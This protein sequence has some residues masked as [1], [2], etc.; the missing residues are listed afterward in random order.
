MQGWP[1]S[2]LVSLGLL[3]NIMRISSPAIKSGRNPCPSVRRPH[4]IDSS[5]SRASF[6]LGDPATQQ[7]GNRRRRRSFHL[8]FP[9]IRDTGCCWHQNNKWVYICALSACCSHCLVGLGLFPVLDACPK[10]QSLDLTSCRG[11]KVVDRRQ[12]FEVRFC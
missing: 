8:Y 11:V 4:R 6:S 1:H 3:K 10:L 12:F 9:V 2:P 7:Y 5:Q